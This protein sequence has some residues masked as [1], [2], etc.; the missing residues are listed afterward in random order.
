M[1]HTPAARCHRV[2][3]AG[4]VASYAVP[5]AARIRRVVR[6]C[7]WF[8]R[9]RTVLLRRPPR[10]ASSRPPTFRPC[11]S[12]RPPRSP[13][14]GF[15][16][17]GG[18]ECGR[19]GLDGRRRAVVR[20]TDAQLGHPGGPGRLVRDLRNHHLR[21]AG[22]GGRGRRARAAVVHDG[23][24]PG[25]QCLMVDLA[26]HEAVVPVVHRSQAGPAAG[27]QD[28]AAVATDRLDGH[29]REVLR[30]VQGHAAEAH[31]H[32][33]STGVQKASSSCGSGRSSG[34]NHAPICTMSRCATSCQGPR[35][36]SAASHG[37]SV[38]VW[39]R[40][41]R[42]GGRP[43]AA[44]WVFS[45]SPYKAFTR[46][47]SCS[48][49]TLR[50]LSSCGDGVPGRAP[51][52]R[53]GDG[54]PNGWKHTYTYGIPSF[55]ATERAPAGI[56]PVATSTSHPSAAAVSVSNRAATSS[57]ASRNA[58]AA[59]GGLVPVTTERTVG[60][61][62]TSGTPAR[63]SSAT[64]S[65]SGGAHTRTSAPSSRSRTASPAS[66]STS[67]RDPHV[68]NST[69]MVES[70]I[71]AGPGFGRPSRGTPRALPQAPVRYTLKRAR[72]WI[73]WISLPFPLP[74]GRRPSR[75]GTPVSRVGG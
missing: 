1:I 56:N 39:S 57:G 5:S 67:P 9:T 32:R 75:A 14:P 19:Q 69:R 4:P 24:H 59:F 25:E 12:C 45:A 16:G 47:S 51:G 49:S 8:T 50:S 22:P 21:R 6:R 11:G 35:T 26:D 38:K 61:S 62:G 54:S 72:R 58:S 3:P 27:E 74:P 63:S 10:R 33:R 34:R 66:G 48:H 20:R 15:R 53:C 73:R 42:T 41:L 43:I 65:S 29:P 30:E 52:R 44:R 64:N 17:Q 68:D 18:V 2:E 55:S 13:V 40:T 37:R 31:V 46:W 71:S 70:P 36:G 23:G 60:P 7:R 28:T